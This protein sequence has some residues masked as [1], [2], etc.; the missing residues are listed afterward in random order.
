MVGKVF[1]KVDTLTVSFYVFDFLCSIFDDGGCGMLNE[2]ASL[3][4]TILVMCL[5]GVGS[6]FRRNLK[7][8]F[9]GEPR[10]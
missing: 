6:I 10:F 9:S 2:L 3:L 1:V 8:M 7:I 5:F 4:L